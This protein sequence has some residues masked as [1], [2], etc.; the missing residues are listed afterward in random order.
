MNS[1]NGNLA[2]PYVNVQRDNEHID[3]YYSRSLGTEPP[4]PELDQEVKTPVCII[5]GGMA[6]LAA[7]DAARPEPDFDVGGAG[8]RPGFRRSR[9]G[10]RDLS[11]LRQSQRRI[12]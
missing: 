4:H 8:V 11:Q 12:P 2:K 3:S 9:P 7:A 5:G 6:G 10:R 1:F